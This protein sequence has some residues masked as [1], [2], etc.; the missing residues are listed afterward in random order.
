M[1]P[2]SSHATLGVK[3]GQ[4]V[5]VSPTLLKRWGIKF[6]ESDLEDTF[7]GKQLRIK[8]ADGTKKVLWNSTK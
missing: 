1:H 3:F 4:S 5:F 7:M 8:E 6:D 2:S